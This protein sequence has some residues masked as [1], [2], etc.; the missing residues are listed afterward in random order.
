MTAIEHNQSATIHN[1]SEAITDAPKL[2]KLRSAVL[3][4]KSQFFFN[5]SSSDTFI[6]AEASTQKKDQLVVV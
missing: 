4:P 3:N 6:I 1:D 5:G 2:S